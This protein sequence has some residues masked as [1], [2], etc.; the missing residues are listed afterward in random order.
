MNTTQTRTVVVPA[1]ESGLRQREALLE[2]IRAALPPGWWVLNLTVEREAGG[3]LTI[4]LTRG[5]EA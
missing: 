4:T 2:S 3:E 5:A 1:D